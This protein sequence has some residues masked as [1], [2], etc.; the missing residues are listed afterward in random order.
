VVFN[1]LLRSFLLARA[2]VLSMM[3]KLRTAGT[4]IDQAAGLVSS[5]DKSKPDSRTTHT[6]ALIRT[7][8]S[9]YIGDIDSCLRDAR[10]FIELAERSGSTW[11]MIVSASALGR[12]HLTG[13]RW[14]QARASLKYALA[15][16]RLHKLGLEAEASFLAHLAE[17]L[18]GCGELKQAQTTAE[19]AVKVAC[20]KK[21]LFWELQARIA[22][23][24]VLL[25]RKLKEEHS[26][27]AAALERA[28]ELIKTTGGN[29]MKPIII[30][31]QAEFARL[32][33]DDD[34][35]RQ[36]LQK[37]HSLFTTTGADG[38]AERLKA[39]LNDS[40]P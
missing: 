27:I 20:Q 17:A 29:V 34:S 13:Q 33:G 23:A 18:T 2:N 14:S 16:A 19:E 15:Q 30:M 11:A 38:H 6:E 22:L 24:E 12:A 32:K 5:V 25:H 1:R 40:E 35:H 9:I 26:Q 31:C 7:N 39:T 3:G 10:H 8:L 28:E 4:L 36:M 37:A 21:T